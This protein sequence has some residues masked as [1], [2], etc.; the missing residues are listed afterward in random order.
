MR[1]KLQCTIIGLIW[2]ILLSII[3]VSAAPLRIGIGSSKS[4]QEF[5]G[6]GCGAMFY[7]E[8]ITS[9]AASNDE[10]RQQELYDDLFAKVNTRYLH[11]MIRATHEPENDNDDPLKPDFEA[12]NFAY[13]EHTIAIAKAAKKRQ[14][15]IEFLATLLTPP[16]WMKTN[17]AESGGGEE[18]ATLKPKM[19]LEFAEYLWAFLQHM[20]GNDV[21]VH[22]LSI[23][24]EPDWPHDQP[25]CFFTPDDYAKLFDTVGDYLDRMA[26]LYPKVP[27][28]QLVGPNTLSARAAARDYLPPL[29]RKAGKHLAVLA[30]HDYDMK[31]E[32]WGDMRKLARDRPVWMTE[33]CSRDADTSPGQIN[34]A[35]AY[36]S[37]MHAG[38]NGGVNVWMAYDWVYPP[39][40]GG[41][42]LVHV[43]WGKGYT[44]NK[45]YWAFRQW[46]EPLKP[47]MRIVECDV[48]EEDSK[49]EATAFLSADRMLVV[50]LTNNGH[51]DVAVQ[52]GLRGGNGVPTRDC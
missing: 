10:K 19:E 17:N 15:D 8:H 39:R 1:K 52:V 24:N 5:Q 18:K 21:P 37:A 47:G 32:R 41:E 33:W 46:A 48:S 12:R 43:D 28:A 40:D 23:A 2:L 30:A 36:A 13:C 51:S 42:A 45:P 34:A 16:A 20:A 7:E 26:K 14:P 25:G 9:L 49:I 50:H 29:Q 11:L 35:M 31:G 22:Y 3:D 4:L 38:F 6:M 44:L 27:K